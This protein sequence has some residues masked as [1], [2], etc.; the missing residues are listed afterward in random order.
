MFIAFML[1][2]LFASCNNASE[3]NTKMVTD[4]SSAEKSNIQAGTGSSI[5]ISTPY[6][7][8]EEEMKD[9]SVFADGSQPTTWA[10]A[11]ITDSIAFKKFLKHLQVWIANNEKDSVASVIVFPM[12]TSKVKSKDG[13]LKNYDNYINDKIK[14]AS[15]NINYKHIFRNNQGAMIGDGAIW[16]TQSG[17][18]Y[19]IFAI[20]N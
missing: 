14:L 16:F 18:G 2:V 8:T 11:G 1:I 20:N 17:D 12:R 5:A 3:N 13:F 9:D 6:D 15:K 10:N 7:L 19:K 4:T